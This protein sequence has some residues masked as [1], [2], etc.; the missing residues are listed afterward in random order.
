MIGVNM[1]NLQGGKVVVSIRDY[2]PELHQPGVIQCMARQ[3]GQHL[4]TGLYYYGS[5]WVW[6]DDLSE[7]RDGAI[8]EAEAA[9]RER[10]GP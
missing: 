8:Q 9:A 2:P 6:P 3:D 1:F 4:G 10:F 5:R 7:R